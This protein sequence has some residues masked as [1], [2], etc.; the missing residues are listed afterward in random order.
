VE[1]L[2]EDLATRALTLDKT[3]VFSKGLKLARPQGYQ[4]PQGERREGVG[5]GGALGG[6]AAGK[7]VLGWRPCFQGPASM[8]LLQPPT[9]AAAQLRTAPRLSPGN[10]TQWL[11][12]SSAPRLL[13]SPPYPAATGPANDK[14]AYAQQLA[15][16][17]AAGGVTNVLMLEGLV[18]AKEVVDEAERQEVRRGARVGREAGGAVIGAGPSKCPTAHSRPC[19]PAP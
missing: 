14:I 6:T 12:A 8:P 16:K 19:S 11:A 9:K 5:T 4:G 3:E 15:A 10:R 1:F 18:D 7:A 2:T 17:L 13:L